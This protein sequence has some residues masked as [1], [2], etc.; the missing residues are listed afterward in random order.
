M[1]T[2][3][4][5]A[6]EGAFA[7]DVLMPGDP[8]RAKLIAESL[9]DG[10]EL[11][12]EVR[13]ILG[14]TGTYRGR[15]VSVLASG[16][17]IPSMAIYAT[18]LIRFYGVRRII[19]VGTVGAMDPA[20]E[21]GDVVAASSAHTNSS[22]AATWVPGVHVSLAPSFELLSKA[23]DAARRT[24]RAMRVGPVLT[25]DSFYYSDPANRGLLASLGTI[26]VDM[27]AAGLYG[28]GM[29]EGAETLMLGTVSDK[30]GAAM[31]ADERERLFTHMTT[32]AL[33]S[34]A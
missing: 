14:Y 27:E 13:G 20:L 12:T 25:T 18:E 19:R 30:P 31:S 22:F 32:I 4:I 24:G 6:P 34:L 11:V 2:P 15:P 5:G 28:V 16:M 9:F 3:H 21:L 7:P 10:A 8:R 33:E 23:A 26:G 29:R 17:G 1:P